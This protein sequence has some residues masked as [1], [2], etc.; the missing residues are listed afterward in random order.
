MLISR[1]IS[2]GYYIYGHSYTQSIF[3]RKPKLT[4]LEAWTTIFDSN[5]HPYLLYPY[6][7]SLIMGLIIDDTIHCVEYT[8][9]RYIPPSKRI[10]FYV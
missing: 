2:P 3:N 10:L 6:I 4:R 5:E 8:N 9:R 7:K 1:G